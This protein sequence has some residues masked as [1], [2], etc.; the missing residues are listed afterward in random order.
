[1]RQL[2]DLEPKV[3]AVMHGPSYAGDGGASLRGL[4]DTYE[5]KYLGGAAE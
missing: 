3:L 4:A 1:M 2:A 5:Q